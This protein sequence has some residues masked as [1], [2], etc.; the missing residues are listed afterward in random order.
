MKKVL[1]LVLALALVLSLTPVCLAAGKGDKRS[2]AFEDTLYRNR[3]GAWLDAYLYIDDPV[4]GTV[5]LISRQKGEDNPFMEEFCRGLEGVVQIAGS[6]NCDFDFEASFLLK[7]GTV[8]CTD[9]C[10]HFDHLKNVAKLSDDASYALLKNGN[11]VSTGDE[12]GAV[13]LKGAVDIAGNE[14]NCFA[15]TRKGEV[16]PLVTDFSPEELAEVK[17]WRNVKNVETFGRSCLIA[18][19]ADGGMCMT[20]RTR[21]TLDTRNVGYEFPEF[22][23]LLLDSSELE[24]VDATFPDLTRDGYEDL[25]LVI[26]FDLLFGDEK[27]TRYSEVTGMPVES[28]LILVFSNRLKLVYSD[29]VNASRD[30]RCELYC[31]FLDSGCYL[32]KRGVDQQTPSWWDGLELYYPTDTGKLVHEPE[33]E[34]SLEGD[35]DT[36][37][38]DPARME[39]LE[40]LDG[41]LENS[42]NLLEF[43]M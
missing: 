1:S 28:K 20:E 38:T 6:A 19:G 21:E 25:V 2:K 17:A 22:F 37:D 31:T 27:I 4:R 42:I 5:S 33:Y 14:A 30:T 9:D 29:V 40:V 36:M 23:E 7:D 24:A 12:T 26:P 11:V 16:V 15:V 43:G 10:G 41:L 35:L 18:Y 32:L 13:L 34:C 8:T 39:F 3:C